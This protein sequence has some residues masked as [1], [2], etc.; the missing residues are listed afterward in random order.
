MYPVNKPNIYNQPK[1]GERFS[2]K[3]G[4]YFWYSSIMKTY[5]KAQQVAWQKEMEEKTKQEPQTTDDNIN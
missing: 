2:L 4:R 1:Q 3:E 5:N